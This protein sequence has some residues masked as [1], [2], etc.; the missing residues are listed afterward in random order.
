MEMIWNKGF[1]FSLRMMNLAVSWRLLWKEEWDWIKCHLGDGFTNAE[2]GKYDV[3]NKE[4]KM[5][6]EKRFSERY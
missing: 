3:W 5:Y 6:M 4:I 2:E 1:M